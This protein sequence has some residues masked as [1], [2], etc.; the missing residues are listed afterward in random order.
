MISVYI[1]YVYIAYMRCLFKH[2]YIFIFKT[3]VYVYYYNIFP[4]YQARRVCV[5]PLVLLPLK[6]EH[7][8]ISIGIPYGCYT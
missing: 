7:N 6:L 4:L 8:I 3:L 2:D 1:I 5:T